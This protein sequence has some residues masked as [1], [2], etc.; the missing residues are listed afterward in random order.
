MKFGDKVNLCSEKMFIAGQGLGG[1]T[2][3]LSG[4]GNQSLFK[5]S[6]SFDSSFWSHLNEV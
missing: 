4:C 1:W 3:I 2:S 6:L 5:A